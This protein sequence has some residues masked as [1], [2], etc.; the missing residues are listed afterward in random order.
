[1]LRDCERERDEPPPE[2]RRLEA[3][4]P[5][6]AVARPEERRL[7]VVRPRLLRDVAMV[8]WGKK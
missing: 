8:G 5:R 2:E 1:M 7:A 3:L 4:R 6:E